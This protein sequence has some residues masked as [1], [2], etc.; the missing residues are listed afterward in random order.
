MNPAELTEAER[1][2]W[3]AFPRGAWTDL[4]GDSVDESRVAQ[5]A[6]Q[7]ALRKERIAEIQ[8]AVSEL[9]LDQRTALVLFEYEGQPMAEIAVALGCSAKAVE[10]R[11]Y[12]AR[13][14]LKG[15]LRLG[16]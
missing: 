5:P 1:L 3:N 4:G 15:A 16:D 9:P 2:L 12:R 8:A 6:S 10:N 11:L 7:V 14:K 13:L